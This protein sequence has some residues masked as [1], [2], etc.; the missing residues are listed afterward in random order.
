MH[1]VNILTELNL[2]DKMAIRKRQITKNLKCEL[3]ENEKASYA[4]E[5]A[6]AELKAQELES[7]KASI[8]K[9]LGNDIKYHV[10]ISRQK[11]KLIK[12]GFEFREVACEELHN[13]E[14]GIITVNRLDS[15][16]EVEERAMTAD[17]R[18]MGFA[19]IFEK[20]E[21]ESDG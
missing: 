6:E 21:E 8:D 10:G 2:E 7:E 3:T 13:F 16:E 15:A 9:R 20:D 5:M 18:Q 19:D 14:R 11:A 12:D 4:A 17:E 1:I